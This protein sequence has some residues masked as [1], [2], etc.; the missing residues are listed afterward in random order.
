MTCR[1][2]GR[3]FG[4]QHMDSHQLHSVREGGYVQRREVESSAQPLPADAQPDV[5]HLLPAHPNCVP[6]CSR[7]V[8]LP[9]SRR[10]GSAQSVGEH[11]SRRHCFHARRRRHDA[12][13]LHFNPDSE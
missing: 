5:P 6:Q 13:Q 4:Q 10:R 9:H 1:L 11:S 12:A 8:R 2:D 3:L 7:R